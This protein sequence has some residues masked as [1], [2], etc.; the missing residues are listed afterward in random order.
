MSR[1]QQTCNL[2]IEGSGVAPYALSLRSFVQQF[3]DADALVKLGHPRGKIQGKSD[4]VKQ[5]KEQCADLMAVAKLSYLVQREGWATER[6]WGTV[7][8]LGEQQRMGM[9]RLFFQR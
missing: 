9:A 4:A 3:L 8:S 1:E 5:L 6:Q 7:L 2:V